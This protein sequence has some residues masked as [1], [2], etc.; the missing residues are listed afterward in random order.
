MFHRLN[1]SNF[2]KGFLIR[3]SIPL[4]VIFVVSKSPDA[5]FLAVWDISL[6][7]PTIERTKNLPDISTAKIIIAPI[8]EK[9][10]M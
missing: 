6:I 1:S 10:T 4:L 5:M 2:E 9:I 3:Y 8:S 7:G